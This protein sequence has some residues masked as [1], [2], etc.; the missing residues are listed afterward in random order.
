MNANTDQMQALFDRLELQL[1]AYQEGFDTLSQAKTLSDLSMKFSRLVRGNLLTT[2]VAVYNSPM[3]KDDWHELTAGR[4]SSAAFLP[5]GSSERY[6]HIASDADDHIVAV[7]PMVDG[8]RFGVIIG[9]KLNT[10]AWTSL[11]KVMVQMFLQLLDNAFQ[12]FRNRQKEKELIFSL[13]HKILQLN[14]LIDTGIHISRL[15]PGRS[16]LEMA[17]ERVI[18]LT[19]AGRGRIQ[20]IRHGGRK[21]RVCFPVDFNEDDIDA[22][23]SIRA[24]FEFQGDA[25]S[26]L[27]ADKESRSGAQVFDENDE[28]LLQA[29]SRQ[30]EAALENHYLYAET[31]EKQRIEQDIAVAA[32]IQQ[33]ILPLALPK[34]PGYDLAGVNV[35]SKSV[36]GDYYDCLPLADGRYALV[37]A[38][39]AGKGIPA[40]LLVSSLQA[41]LSAY[42]D[43]LPPLPELNVKL[44]RAIHKASTED[45]YITFFIAIL[46]PASGQLESYN[47]G[48]N[49]IY[50]HRANGDWQELAEGG[51]PVGMMAMDF[52]G[53]SESTILAPGD[54]LLLYT[55]GVTEAMNA[56]EEEYDDIVGLKGFFTGTPASTA[57]AFIDSLVADIRDFTGD[58]A[59]SDDITAMLLMR[60]A[61]G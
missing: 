48:H 14:S 33:K 19:N 59:Q 32:E 45:K 57:T 20:I 13:N 44:N 21:E 58:V 53:Q 52:P 47:A 23:A 8:S 36:G 24:E 54:R 15:N 12:A 25:Y 4:K 46:D 42:L 34:I 39:V 18:P 30:V 56:A 16:L 17:L 6:L 35:P 22:T 29:F 31:L 41:L 49:P 28:T 10:E 11:D 27:L 60:N 50:L 7:L 38:D 26:M 43:A 40:S 55:D 9:A 3:G 5:P 1:S 37:I 2:E 61:S 51:I